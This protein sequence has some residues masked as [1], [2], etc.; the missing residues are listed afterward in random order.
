MSDNG[1]VM[2]QQVCRA[3]LQRSVGKIF[4]HA[5]FEE[6]QPSALDAITDIAGSFFKNLVHTL[7]VYSEVPKARAEQAK[8]SSENPV[9]KPRFTAEEAILHSLHE[10]GVDL[11]ALET[12]VKDDVDRLGSKLT[13]MHDRMRS[14]LAELLVSSIFMSIVTN[15][16]MVSAPLSTPM[17]EQ[18]ALALSTTAASSSLVVILPKTSTRISLVSRSL[19]STRSSALL[20]SV[21]LSTCCRIACTMRTERKTRGMYLTRVLLH[22]SHLTQPLLQRYRNVRRHLRTTSSLRSRYHRKCQLPNRPRA[23][24]LPPQAARKQ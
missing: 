19:V 3:A 1:P 6:F 20:L 8:A 16:Y 13:V 22:Q 23:V 5:G 14:H 17:P 11:E 18:T 7:G 21:C 24:I 12:Y 10:N 2:S 4:Y 15:A 9:S